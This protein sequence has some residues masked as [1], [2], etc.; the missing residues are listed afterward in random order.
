MLLKESP[1]GGG[2]GGHTPATASHTTSTSAD[3]NAD[4]ARVAAAWPA[5]IPGD[6]HCDRC[7][8]VILC[9]HTWLTPSG[10]YEPPRPARSGDFLENI[11]RG[12]K[13]SELFDE[14]NAEPADPRHWLDVLRDRSST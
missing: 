8:W 5:D 12:M 6:I 7:G 1:P 2:G 14:L 4:T 11:S 13:S 3:E 10:R 9:P